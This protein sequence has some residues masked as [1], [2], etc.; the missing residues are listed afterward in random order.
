MTGK[1]TNARGVSRGRREQKFCHAEQ[2][3][4]TAIVLGKNVLTEPFL[5]DFFGDLAADPFVADEPP[6]VDDADVPRAIPMR[7]RKST[8]DAAAMATTA[9]SWTHAITSIFLN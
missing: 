6:L 5:G 9:L 8:S 4:S 1:Q 7:T 2:I 3:N